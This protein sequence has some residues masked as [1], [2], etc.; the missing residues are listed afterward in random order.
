M[1]DKFY[2]ATRENVELIPRRSGIYT[3]FV[4]VN[5][6]GYIRIIG[7]EMKKIIFKKGEIPYDYMEHLLLGLSTISYYGTPK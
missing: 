7:P 2:W 1:D 3:I 6:S 5:G 4:A